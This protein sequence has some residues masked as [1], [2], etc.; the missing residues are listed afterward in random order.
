MQSPDAID[1]N[2]RGIYT[3]MMEGKKMGRDTTLQALSFG[4]LAP[5]PILMDF[6]P[7]TVQRVDSIDGSYTNFIKFEPEEPSS[8][9]A[10]VCKVSAPR[11]PRLGEKK[12]AGGR[13]EREGWGARSAPRPTSFLPH[14]PASRAGAPRAPSC[15]PF[16]PPSPDR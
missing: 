4:K 2:W 6:S 12:V 15:C 16:D 7:S 13:P 9:C 14:C 8:G 1:G 11:R 5:L 3:T 10:G